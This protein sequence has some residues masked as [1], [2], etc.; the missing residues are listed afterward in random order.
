MS[1]Y[2]G[3]AVGFAALGCYTFALFRWWHKRLTSLAARFDLSER[4][5]RASWQALP[6]MLLFAVPALVVLVIS[7]I[8]RSVSGFFIVA[9]FILVMAPT[10]VWCLRQIPKLRA[11][12]YYRGQR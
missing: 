11:L 6:V 10:V 1:A 12:G 8:H 2:L 7:M 5:K 3:V 4:R 9:A